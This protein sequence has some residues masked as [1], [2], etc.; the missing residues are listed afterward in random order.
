MRKRI[1]GMVM[2]ALQLVVILGLHVQAMGQEPPLRLQ[3]ETDT[4]AGEAYVAQLDQKAEEMKRRIRGTETAVTVSGTAYYVADD[5]DD[6]RDGRSPESAWAT[7]ARVNRAAF[8]SGDAVYFKRGDVFRGQLVLHNGVT[9]SAYGTGE[10]P[11]LYGSPENGADPAKWTRA[12][13]GTNIW[14]YETA[15]LDV[16]LVVFNEGQEWS[17]KAIPSYV[18]GQYVKR[19]EP[20]KPFD[21]ATDLVRDLQCFSQCDTQIVNGLP[22]KTAKGKLYLRCDRGNPGE[23]FESIEF[24]TRLNIIEGG[25]R[26][27]VLVDNLCIR[28]GGSHGVGAGRVENF[29]VQNCEFGWIG[30]GIQYYHPVSGRVVRYGNAVEV[31]SAC[32]GYQVLNNYI[33]QAYDAGITHQQAT[34]G[35]EDFRLEDVVYAGNLVEDCTYSI[36]Y[37]MGNPDPETCVRMMKNISIRDN[38]LR[39]AG[40]GFGA[41]RPYGNQ[42][43][44]L[45]GW[46][47]SWNQAENFVIE[48]NILDRST[49]ALFQMGAGSAAWLPQLKGNTYVQTLGALL[50]YWG[51]NPPPSFPYDADATDTL[52]QVMKDETAVVY[53][54]N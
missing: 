43:A 24:C 20:S 5:G 4:A 3:T 51:V 37:F 12:F 33:Y 25:S 41:Q 39:R 18:Q 21:I 45:K 40:G 27:N 23:V 17:T 34:D 53:Y 42:E 32:K 2:A 31:Y 47:S 14:V 9:Y 7:L 48:N 19:D 11:R 54:V 28:Y 1:A 44:H 16:G 8:S 35:K 30:G 36:E 46:A 49:D 38:L 6:S 15:M 10:K 26:R 50:G 13:A 22:A 52:R 29:T